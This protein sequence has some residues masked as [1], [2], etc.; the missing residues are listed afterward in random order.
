MDFRSR[1]YRHAR[2]GGGHEP[3]YLISGIPYIQMSHG[4]PGKPFQVSTY[5][6]RDTLE[7]F[8]TKVDPSLSKTIDILKIAMSTVRVLS[9]NAIA[10]F[11]VTHQVN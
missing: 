9:E 8:N 1:G 4:V 10:D 2:N 5:S 7:N 3:I 11:D 6:N